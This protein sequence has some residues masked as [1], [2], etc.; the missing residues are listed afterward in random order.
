MWWTHPIICSENTHTLTHFPFH[1]TMEFN[2]RFD[3]CEREHTF[4]A[5]SLRAYCVCCTCVCLKKDELCSKM[6]NAQVECWKHVNGNRNAHKHS[7]M[8]SFQR[9]QQQYRNESIEKFFFSRVSPVC[10]KS[11][12]NDDDDDLNKCMVLQYWVHIILFL[13]QVLWLLLLL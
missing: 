1:S 4:W 6:F 7:Y 10:P 2:H 9:S 12:G 8:H 11:W 3:A 13:L 5:I